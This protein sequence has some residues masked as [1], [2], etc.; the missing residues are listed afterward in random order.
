MGYVT[1]KQF[2]KYYQRYY[3]DR[4]MIQ[5]IARKLS[6]NDEELYKELVQ[7][8]LIRLWGLDLRKATKNEDAYIR[9]AIKFAIIDYLR[10]NSPNK[11]ESLDARLLAGE[12][13]EKDSA[14]GELRLISSRQ[15]V[16]LDREYR[17][18]GNGRSTEIEEDLY[19]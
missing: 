1:E 12:Q 19:E 11:Y 4:K 6:M 14:T 15:E 16:R 18:H 8:G 5:R 13:L 9:Q 10:R 2:E 7:E 17:D 3:V